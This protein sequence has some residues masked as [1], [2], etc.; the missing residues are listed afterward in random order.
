[1]KEVKESISIRIPQSQHVAISRAAEKAGTSVTG[2]ISDMLAIAFE[3][4][5][6]DIYALAALKA[7]CL[8]LAGGDQERASELEKQFI[9]DADAEVYRDSMAKKKTDLPTAKEPMKVLTLRLDPRLARW[10][11]RSA[12]LHYTDP[13]RYIRDVLNMVM[14]CRYLRAMSKALSQAKDDCL[15]GR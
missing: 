12:L 1:M 5:S 14:D 8:D 7:K 2:Y 13:S 11:K 15:R 3:F 4:E 6:A 10:T 9:S